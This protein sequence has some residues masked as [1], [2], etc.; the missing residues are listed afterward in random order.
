MLTKE[1]LLA[2]N[3][4]AP[5][6]FD[7]KS[8]WGVVYLKQFNGVDAGNW[9]SWAANQ[10]DKDTGELLNP[11]MYR[12]TLVQRSICDDKGNLIFAE[13]DI[14]QLLGSRADVL[15]EIFIAAVY[16]NKLGVTEV[17]KERLGFSETKP[18]ATGTG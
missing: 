13:N 16:L 2:L 8:D 11:A 5:V 6:P 14:P 17:A 12:A 9:H 7:T 15:A 1:Q 4:F 10:I 18:G 3:K